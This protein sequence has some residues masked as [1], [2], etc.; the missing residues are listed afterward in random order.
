MQEPFK[1]IKLTDRVYW[2]GAIDWD[3]RDFHGYLTQRGSTYNAYLVLA[4]KV[5]LVDTVK[6]PFFDEMMA[7]VSSLI[8]PQQIEVLISNHAEMDHS[9]ALP[10]TI[11]A[12]K[13]TSIYASTVGV[14]AL[15]AHFHMGADIVAVADG[16]QVDLGGEAVTFAET[17]MCH[18]PD[19]M[20]SYLH[21]DRLLFSQDGFGM[22]LATAE[23]FADEIQPHVLEHEALKYY[24]NILLPLSKFVVNTLDKLEGLGLPIEIVAPDHGPI[25]R[26]EKDIEWI[27][28]SYRRWAAQE[29]TNR[30]VVVYDTMWGSTE[31]MAHLIQEGLTQ[32][33][34]EAQLMP[35]RGCHR[36]DIATELLNCGAL[37]IGTPTLNNTMFPTI[38]DVLTYI[39][40]LKP[41]NKVAAAFGSFGWGGE[42]VKQVHDILVDMGL[43]VIG[44]GLKVKYVPDEPA[45]AECRRLGTE[46]ASRMAAKVA[47][48]V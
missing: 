35:A 18:W 15:E 43:D 2:V 41:I 48:H 40:G 17:R 46:I 39:R 27:L 34:A 3:V 38:A 42:A 1:A 11:D 19:S 21:E 24:A 20:V 26:T 4:E 8:D 14:K 28:G 6:A 23:R 5:T 29:P 36:S 37:I 12:V 25:Y 9:G 16:Q 31:R 10:K 32:A 7:R 45:L 33:G 30:A 44:D 47:Q 13:P 22:H